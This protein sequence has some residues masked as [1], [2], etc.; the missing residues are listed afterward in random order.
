MFESALGYT[1]NENLIAEKD[2]NCQRTW[3]VWHRITSSALL[4]MHSS[5]L[6]LYQR[7]KQIL[8]WFICRLKPACSLAWI[9]RMAT[10]SESFLLK[11]SAALLV[12]IASQSKTSE[13]VT[14]IA[15]RDVH[16]PQVSYRVHWN[17]FSDQLKF[18]IAI[19]I[20]LLSLLWRGE[21]VRVTARW[22]SF[23]RRQSKHNI[24][25]CYSQA[26]PRQFMMP[27][28]HHSWLGSSLKVGTESVES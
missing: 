19:L 6:C 1:Y 24:N 26:C 4:S 25:S 3:V 17:I 8:L 27:L 9:S 11:I 2:T 5:G 16:N 10:T 28:S 13:D 18:W 21:T 20:G 12:S 7:L 23:V 14:V 15:V 22:H